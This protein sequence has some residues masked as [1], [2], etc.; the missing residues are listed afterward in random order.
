MAIYRNGHFTVFLSAPGVLVAC[1]YNEEKDKKIK[2]PLWIE[3]C[4]P[5]PQVTC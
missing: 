3:L 4:L 1:L 5:T 2:V